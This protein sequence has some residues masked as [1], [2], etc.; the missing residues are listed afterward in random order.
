[1][2]REELEA[3]GWIGTKSYDKPWEVRWRKGDWYL[4][5]TWSYKPDTN[6]SETCMAYYVLG[7]PSIC[8]WTFPSPGL[9]K[10]VKTREDLDTKMAYYFKL[11]TTHIQCVCKACGAKFTNICYEKHICKKCYRSKKAL[12]NCPH[13]KIRWLAGGGTCID[14]GDDNWY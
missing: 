5:E 12:K 9:G 2:S 11:S 8:D 6:L 14:C 1:M 3:S 13:D 4:K 10:V 7:G